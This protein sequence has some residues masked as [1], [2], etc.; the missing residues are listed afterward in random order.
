MKITI[1]YDSQSSHARQLAEGT[2]VGIRRVNGVCVQIIAISE[3]GIPW[4]NLDASDAIIFGATTRNGEISRCFEHFMQSSSRQ[5]WRGLKWRGK[6]AGGFTT[7]VPN[8]DEDLNIQIGLSLFAAQHRMT[9]VGLESIRCQK[10]R[11]SSLDPQRFHQR[12]LD[13]PQT[14]VDAQE[15]IP[16][17]VDLQTVAYLGERVAKAVLW[18]R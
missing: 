1:V 5:A 2:A 16:S 15:R 7:S 9:W 18:L 6:I 11:K 4:Q 12:D 10:A 8:S 14:G 17:E 13:M 3:D